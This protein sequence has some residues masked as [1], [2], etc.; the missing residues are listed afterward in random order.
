MGTG[1]LIPREQLIEQSVTD[2]VRTAIFTEFG[3]SPDKVE[4]VESFDYNQIREG[5]TK[6]VVTLGFS[7]DDGG[8]QAELG[9]DLTTRVHTIEFFAFGLTNTW[10]RNLAQVVKHVLERDQRIPLYDYSDAAKPLIDYLLPHAARAARQPIADPE[11]WEQYVWT[12]TVQLED[13]YSASLVA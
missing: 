11:P 3:Y 7:F 12:T 6:N 4:L 5:L 2:Y 9:S 10:A 13:T 1:P 8:T